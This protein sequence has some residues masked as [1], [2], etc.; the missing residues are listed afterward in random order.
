MAIINLPKLGAV[1]F[2]DDLTPEQ[3]NSEI[4]RLAKKYDFEVPRPEMGLGT[5]AKRGVVRGAKQLGSAFGDVIP[6]MVASGLGF[7]EYAQ[8]QMGEAAE[9]QAEIQANYRPM[10]RG[11]EDVRGISDYPGFALE[12]IAEQVPNIGT[13]LIPGV[14]LGVTA[15]RTA[16]TSLAKE[17]AKRGLTGVAAE[18]FIAQNAAKVATSQA[19]GQA[20]G[21][22]LGSYAQN[23]PEIFQNIYEATGEMEPGVAALFG[24]VSSALDAVLPSRI[25][26]GMTQPFKVSVAE[27]ILER[28]G[29]QSGL[30]RKTLLGTTSGAAFEGL[31]ES[32]QE[33]ISIAAEKFVDDNDAIWDSKD[34]DRMIQAGVKGA[35]AGGA[36]GSVGGVGEQAAYGR[37]RR[38]QYEAALQKRADR[39]RAGEITKTEAELE[40]MQ[41]VNAQGTLPGFETPVATGLYTPEQEA[42]AEKELKGK[43]LSLFDEAGAPSK[44]A[45]KSVTAGEKVAKKEAAEAE[46]KRKAELAQYNK[47]FKEAKEA[48]E[49][50]VLSLAPIGKLNLVNL[51]KGVEAAP[52]ANQLE[53]LI[54]KANLDL[55][56]IA[57]KRGIPKQEAAEKIVSGEIVPTQDEVIAEPKV[58]EKKGPVAPQDLPTRIDD[59]SLAA[60]GIGYTGKIRKNKLLDGKD[61][62]DPAQAAEVK[63]VLE[64]YANGKNLSTS[65]RQKIEAFL[66]RPEFQFQ[67]EEAINEQPMGAPVAGANQLGVSDIEQRTTPSFAETIGEP[68]AEGLGGVD[69]TT[70]LPATR[71]ESIDRPLGVKE[72]ADLAK[73]EGSV[74]AA[75]EEQVDFITANEQRAQDLITAD[76]REAANKQNI[77]ESELPAEDFSQTDAFKFY[78]LPALFQE[79]F[80]LQDI[81]SMPTRTAA[82]LAQRNRN[83][84][85][86]QL[87]QEAIGRSGPEA[88]AIL[89]NLAEVPDASR[90]AYLAQINKA[91]RDASLAEANTRIEAAKKRIAES[92]QTQKAVKEEQ[93]VQG[94]QIGKAV[95]KADE[96]STMELKLKGLPTT[97]KEAIQREDFQ[98]FL[99]AKLATET[100]PDTRFVLNK[101]KKLGLKTKIKVGKVTPTPGSKQVEGL[102]GSYDPATDT[103][104]IDPELG[105]NNRAVMHELVHA[106]ISH[107]LNNKNHPLTKELT[108]LFE[109]IANQLGSVYG[110]QDLQEF[111][112]ELTSNPDFQAQLKAIQAPRGGNMFQR[113]IQA[114]AEFFG[115]RKG[116]NA[117]EAGL[118]TINDILD[119]SADVEASP[120]DKM[121][122]GVGKP[123]NQAFNV[124]GDI[125]KNMPALAGR[126]IEDTRNTLSNIKGRGVLDAAMSI[127][128]LDNLNTLYKKQ[129]PSIQKLL[130][131]LELRLGEQE[132]RIKQI[133]DN[134]TRFVKAVQANPEQAK[135]MDDMAIDARLAGVDPLDANFKTTPTNVQEYNR[136]RSVYT[137]L[138]KSLQEVYSTIRKDYEASLN[139]YEKLILSAVS[140]SL[141]ARL[142]QEFATKKRLTAYVPFL[143]RGDFWVEYAD[144][145]SGERA[146]H[147]FESIRERE[148]F[149]NE[150]NKQN[151]QHR[152]YENLENIR[153][154]QN[155]IPPTSFIGKIMKD[156]QAN[157]AS[158]EQLDSIYQSYLTLFPG[159]SIFKQFMKA[160]NVRG[161]ERDIVR[162]YGDTMIKWARKI[163]NSKYSPQI[164]NAL[165]E[166]RVQAESANEPQVTAAAQNI[167]GQRDFFHNPTFGKFVNAATTF[168]YFEYIAG[169]ISSAL[170]NVT[171]LPMLV[172]PTLGAKFGFDQAASAMARASKVAINGID[173]DKKYANLYKSLM[174]HAQLKHT[175]AR[176]V[177]EGR[178]VTTQD[179]TGL[180]AKILDGLSIPFAATEQYNRATTA[181]AAYDL[182]K[183][184][185]MSEADAIRYAVDTVKDL[186]TSGMAATAPR[187]FQTGPGRVFFTFKS[188]VWNS[189][190]VMARAF[191][192]AYKGESPEIRREARRQLLGTYGMTMAFAGA[193]G[194]PFYGAVKT[195]AT[196]IAALFGDDDEPFD[197]DEEMRGFFNELGFKGAFNYLTNIELSNRVG[198]ATDL[199]FRDD[200]RGVAEHG[201]VLSAMQQAFGPAGSYL[202]NAERSIKAMNEGHVDR[203]IEGLA[204][205]WIRNAMKGTRYLA[206]GATTLKGDPIMEDISVYN[207][208]MQAIGFAPADLSS[209][210]E[211]TSARKSYEREVLQRHA[212]LLNLYDMAK[213]SGDFELMGEVQE[214]IN[215]F[216][217]AHPGKSITNE[218]LIKSYKERR[219]RE[220]ELVDGISYNRKLK[221]EI[222]EKFE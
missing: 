211:K 69:Q 168:S 127:M 91:G 37:Q 50:N 117:Y 150:L 65:I 121:F 19:T 64:A 201:Y 204:P 182:A 199:V 107:V 175:M 194:L 181:I 137:Q 58:V 185:G 46:K 165:D 55:E 16:A 218:T 71:E 108:K 56:K 54:A 5:I 2:R 45:A 31:T 104:T 178:R 26:K 208:L 200:P 152:S 85:E 82:E 109:N 66:N 83:Q 173:K 169:N 101:I 146:A 93:R 43:Q 217:V 4:D 78:R 74:A 98:A 80:R 8:E 34:F 153:F 191:H 11:T 209:V 47:E 97:V 116:T 189:A 141:K 33:A 84:Q 216:N 193:K 147:A 114:I 76:M 186:H 157:G 136:L 164:D 103:I 41:E 62:S 149:I 187:L 138:P 159:E 96:V 174:D 59:S 151:I 177:L 110:A 72:Q 89:R 61:I 179:F 139:E 202:I 6:A 210:Y 206:E 27:K 113:M 142:Q 100:D 90:Q 30:L 29:M 183:S 42:A 143:R 122:L 156:L 92:E 134:H 63:S 195:L 20:A 40:A 94:K 75:E 22:Y 161:M 160:Q 203:A 13:S 73:A 53:Q 106:A 172:W 86:L 60:L 196:M 158:Q 131:A 49:K 51:A 35:V 140:P 119:I 155:Q 220:L 126:A 77:P 18:Q 145:A 130:D 111:A 212:K 148:L 115:F 25:L 184:K 124:V 10:Y 44:G 154:N 1:N 105:M 23:A 215:D 163:T 133:N 88:I 207:G 57:A 170:I 12:T 38:A 3:F 125:G 162:G 167:M 205:S 213:T 198:I 180:K 219:R 7:D 222:M 166:I 32:A 87:V 14:G 15:A 102:A 144:P 81:M 197:F 36:F 221:P 112:A 190:F 21:I 129:L 171:S 48:L 120:A 128:R 123:V 9:T 132:N 68:L 52:G 70:N 39:V 214:K 135:K 28:S 118:K 176:E 192:Q 188:Y 24:T 79:F 95:K 67:T 99:E 17:A